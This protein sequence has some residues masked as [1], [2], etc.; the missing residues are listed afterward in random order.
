MIHRRGRKRV[1]RHIETREEYTRRMRAWV[2]RMIQQCAKE[3]D[4]VLK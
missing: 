1:P 4:A 3:I 2:L